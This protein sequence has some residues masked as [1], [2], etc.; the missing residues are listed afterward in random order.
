MSE[1]QAKAAAANTN[2]LDHLNID[3]ALGGAT[4]VV[5]GRL[6]EANDG[7]ALN[8]GEYE[9]AAYASC[10]LEYMGGSVKIKL[11]P[12]S[13]DHRQLDKSRAGK[14]AIFAIETKQKDVKIGSYDKAVF[15]PEGKPKL[16]F[17]EPS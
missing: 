14:K 15:I 8:Q 2:I 1:A 4:V 9:G 17:V 6:V 7:S 11:R 3:P 12:G 13:E 10:L 5:S 16:L